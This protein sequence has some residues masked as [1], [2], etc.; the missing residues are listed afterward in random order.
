MLLNIICQL[1]LIAFRRTLPCIYNSC[2]LVEEGIHVTSIILVSFCLFLT[3]RI[4]P[5]S[6]HNRV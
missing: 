1:N 6:T 2:E 4:R 3:V 5:Y